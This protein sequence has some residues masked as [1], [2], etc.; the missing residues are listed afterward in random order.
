MEYT[1]LGNTDI[2]PLL[3]RLFLAVMYILP[4]ICQR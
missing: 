4:M 1:K 2:F 3:T